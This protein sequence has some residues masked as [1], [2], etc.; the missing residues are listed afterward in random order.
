MHKA[1]LLSDAPA[2]GVVTSGPESE[3]HCPELGLCPADQRPARLGCKTAT[4]PVAAHPIVE[5]ED[6][7]ASS[8][9][10][11]NPEHR[12]TLAL[13]QRE[14]KLTADRP[15]MCA[16]GA[17]FDVTLKARFPGPRHPREQLVA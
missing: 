2:G 8:V 11:C 14:V 6:A 16:P 9:E 4:R 1:E 13:D 12:T 3:L 15:L 5:L 10:P 17:L 7:F